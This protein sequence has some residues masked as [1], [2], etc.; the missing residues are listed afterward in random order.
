MSKFRKVDKMNFVVRDCTNKEFEI[1]SPPYLLEL[2][3]YRNW[4]LLIADEKKWIENQQWLLRLEELKNLYP[5][6]NENYKKN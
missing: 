5:Q 6:F 2:K 1:E 3:M 4:D